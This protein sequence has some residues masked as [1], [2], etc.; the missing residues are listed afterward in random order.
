MRITKVTPIFCDGGW[1][2]FTFIKVETDED[3]VGYGE[4]T[5]NRSSF[6]IGGCIRDLESRLIGQDPTVVEKRYWDMC[7]HF[8]QNPGGIAQKA[9][10]G[11]EVA[12]W[13]IKAKALN[14]PLYELFGG[15]LWD[16]IRVYWSHCGTYRA[17]SPELF[18]TSP[19]MRT[20]DD[21]AKLGE[22]VV[23]R[24]Y[25][26][27][28]TNIIIP[29]E[30]PRMLRTFDQNIDYNILKAIDKLISTFRKAVGD[31]VDI[32]LDLNFNFKTEG[33]IQV[34]KVV[35]PYNLMWLELD[36]YDPDALLQIKQSTK[37]PICSAENLYTMK[38]Y[39]PYLERHAMDVCMID[40]PWN[41]YIES[42]RIAALADM[43]E[44]MVSPHN[45]YS[46]L[47]TFMSAHL[48]TSVPN[49]KIMET[50]VDSVPW[51]DDI[52]TELPDIKD[53]YINLP[54]KPG[55]GAELNE[56]E[57]ARHPWPK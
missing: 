32:C 26:A 33:F 17:R 2:A 52:I 28:K 38:G 4:C 49:V 35:E 39:Q 18:T 24:G 5:D 10:A 46:H 7:Q 30:R 15:P 20:M 25:T 55:I 14:V 19:P 53:G 9:I 44:T 36:I 47:S 29:G 50:D 31:G 21:I 56:R 51:R 37:V 43:Y 54:K 42:R 13:D 16:K 8:Q 1:R 48:C 23:A 12:L 40:L 34:A 45:Y 57:I 6:G 27:L 3:L 41:G 11:I 22:E